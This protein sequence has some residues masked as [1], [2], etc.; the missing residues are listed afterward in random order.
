M[1]WGTHWLGPCEGALVQTDFCKKLR[2]APTG[3]FP[4]PLGYFL[5]SHETFHYLAGKPLR[6]HT[7][8][9]IRLIRQLNGCM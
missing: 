7:D 5:A 8:L 9:A 6:K 2:A 4:L 1:P 3:P